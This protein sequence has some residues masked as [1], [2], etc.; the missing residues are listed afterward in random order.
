MA[1]PPPPLPGMAP[2]PPLLPEMVPPPPP[3]PGLQSPEPLLVPEKATQL[4]T[5][6][7]SS[8]ELMGLGKTIPNIT[9]GHRTVPTRRT[10]NN[11][12]YY[13]LPKTKMK[14]LNWT[15]VNNQYLGKVGTILFKRYTFIYLIARLNY[16]SLFRV[17][18]QFRLVVSRPS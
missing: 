18:R 17:F 9:D 10:N 16:N 5:T 11:I 1:P 15:K 14:T 13:S 8:M 7:S 2:P 4:L 6:L 3:F 12:K